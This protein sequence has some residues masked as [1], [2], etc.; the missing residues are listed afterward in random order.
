MNGENVQRPLLLVGGKGG[1]GKT[2]CSAAIAVRFASLGN[3]T[4]LLTSDLSP[5]LSDIF[6]RKLG[7][8]IT[9]VADNLDAY[10]ISQDS[11]AA[12]WKKRFGRDFYDILAV[13]IDIESL[14]S[15]SSHEIMDYIG[16]APSLREETMLDIIVHLAADHGYDR[17]VWDTAP[18]GETLNLLGMPKIIKKHLRAGAKVFEG[19]DKIGK[20]LIGKRPIAGI[21]DEWVL[22]SEKIARFIHARSSFLVVANPE[23][24]V[25]DQARRLIN[26][27]VE[28]K[29]HIRGLVINKMIEEADSQLLAEMKTRQAKYVE[30][31]RSI[32]G[33]RRVA[34]LPVS[35]REI[36][37]VAGLQAI[38]EK[39]VADLAL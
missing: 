24:L 10:E 4:L 15:E 21:M 32:A 3:R 39:L 38:G 34:M 25:V 36:G 35:F 14:E 17:I 7:S 16:S 20:N 29:L 18:A 23:S 31:L 11:I 13:L 5:S 1:V 33:S 30:E 12:H 2:T 26:T 27:L 8:S 6:A 28:Y 22:V 19:L 37:G 9:R